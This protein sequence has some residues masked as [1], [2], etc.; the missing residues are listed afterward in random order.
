MQPMVFLDNYP[1]NSVWDKP[2]GLKQIGTER[3]LWRKQA[4]DDCSV[5]LECPT[6]YNCPS[7]DLSLNGHYYA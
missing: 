2:K 3:G 5:L 4:P 1:N 7:Y 6:S